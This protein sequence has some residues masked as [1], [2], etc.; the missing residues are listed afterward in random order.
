MFRL[1]TEPTSGYLFKKKKWYVLL[2]MLV[3]YEI[4][5]HYLNTV[6]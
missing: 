3:D 5:L 1:V 4:V 6:S 2:T